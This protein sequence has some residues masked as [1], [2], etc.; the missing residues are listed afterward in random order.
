M[1]NLFRRLFSFVLTPLESGT[2]PYQYKASHRSILVVMSIM[3]CGLGGLVFYA[4]PDLAS[5]YWLPVIVFG[6]AGITG[7]VVASLGSDRTVAKLWGSK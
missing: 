4:M 5:G 6:G 2:E 1:K 7:L 3:F